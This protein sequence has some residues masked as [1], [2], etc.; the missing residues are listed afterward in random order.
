MNVYQSIF[1]SPAWH[2]RHLRVCS[3]RLQCRFFLCFRWPLFTSM[4]P[5]AFTISKS[6]CRMTGQLLSTSTKPTRGSCISARSLRR[7]SQLA[8]FERAPT[9]SDCIRVSMDQRLVSS[10]CSVGFRFLPQSASS[11]LTPTGSACDLLVMEPAFARRS[12]PPRRWTSGAVTSR[13][14]HC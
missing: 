12:R 10:W 4:A 3:L 14:V 5:M 11:L 8:R 1:H 9:A 2:L 6:R 7:Q 13:K